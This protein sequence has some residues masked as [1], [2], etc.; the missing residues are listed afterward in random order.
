MI[1]ALAVG[2]RVYGIIRLYDK[3][4]TESLMSTVRRE[5]ASGRW[6]LEVRMIV[7]DYPDSK[8]DNL[9]KGF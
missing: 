1:L 8:Y 4:G 5:L 6:Q 7:L 9:R 3:N 2:R